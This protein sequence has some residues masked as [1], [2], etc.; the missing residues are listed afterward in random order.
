VSSLE[1]VAVCVCVSLFQGFCLATDG[2]QGGN[3]VH[4]KKG[5]TVSRLSCIATDR[6]QGG[7][8]VHGKGGAWKLD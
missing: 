5:V 2:H 8:R 7:N 4:G 6:H 3:R 1:T